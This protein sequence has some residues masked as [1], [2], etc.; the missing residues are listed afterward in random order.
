MSEIAF[1]LSDTLFS[2]LKW[3]Q[4]QGSVCSWMSL[5]DHNSLANR[6]RFDASHLILERASCWLASI[7]PVSMDRLAWF[8]KNILQ[9]LLRVR[10]LMTAELRL[11]RA[12]SDSHFCRTFLPLIIMYFWNNFPSKSKN[13]LLTVWLREWERERERVDEFGYQAKERKLFTLFMGAV[14]VVY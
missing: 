13:W 14:V 5:S 3:N 11:L 10:E 8:N 1:L 4:D 12:R 7:V 6:I 9:V 2:R